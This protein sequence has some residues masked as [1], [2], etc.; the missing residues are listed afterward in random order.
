VKVAWTDQALS[1]LGAIREYVAQDSPTAAL[2]LVTSLVE[3]G[4]SLS[5]LSRRGRLLPGHE[6]R[7]IR[8]VLEGNYRIVYRVRADVVEILT[9]FERHRLLPEEDLW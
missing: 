8:E 2:R 4:D 1:R 9:V 5:R 3:R 7:R 6:A